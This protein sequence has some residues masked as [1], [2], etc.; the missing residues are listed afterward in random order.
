MA[1]EGTICEKTEVKAS[2][3]HIPLSTQSDQV[4]TIKLYQNAI[5]DAI[6]G[7]GSTPHAPVS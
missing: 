2:R 6:I 5:A 1:W 4:Q 3:C 7:T